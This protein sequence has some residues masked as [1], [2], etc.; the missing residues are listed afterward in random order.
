MGYRLIHPYLVD[1]LVSIRMPRKMGM[2]S[3]RALPCTG[4]VG[5][6]AGTTSLSNISGLK[7]LNQ[8]M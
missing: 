6:K 5:L 8:V 2:S 3:M 4:A 1:I 7:K